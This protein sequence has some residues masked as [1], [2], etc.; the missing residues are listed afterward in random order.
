MARP[1]GWTRQQ[2]LV[3]FYL[4]CRLPFGKMHSR[5]PDIIRYA[6]WIGRTPNALAMKLTNIASLDPAII[7]SGRSGLPGA[8]AADRAMWDE[9]NGDWEAFSLDSH[10]V[11]QQLD[12]SGERQKELAQEI[13]GTA[14]IQHG[15]VSY[16]GSNRVV[17]T[18]ARIGQNLFRKAVLSAYNN[19]CCISGL[20][21]PTFLIASHI[22]PWRDD[23]KH[24]LNPHNGLCLSVLHDRAFD[25][26]LLAVADDRTVVVSPK[27]KQTPDAFMKKTVLEYEGKTI[28]LPEKFEP[29]T[30]FLSH[31]YEHIFISG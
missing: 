26:G 5:N 22:I 11:V 29:D 20:S 14:D 21:H 1:N 30:V 17:T 15:P 19:R 12:Q 23:P 18:K 27:L 13:D 6:H 24:R 9:M 8:S 25:Q 28:E 16:E 10:Q 31:H 4:Y 7:N 3:A 2:L